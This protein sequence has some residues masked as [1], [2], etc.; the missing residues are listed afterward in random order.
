MLSEMEESPNTTTAVNA[1]GCRLSIWLAPRW[2]LYEPK[3]YTGINEATS[4]FWL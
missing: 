3:V 4:C 2:M 1:N